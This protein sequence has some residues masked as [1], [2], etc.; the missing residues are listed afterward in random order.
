MTDSEKTAFQLFMTEALEKRASLI[1]EQ[2]RMEKTAAML[3]TATKIAGS[4]SPNERKV[5][6]LCALIDSALHALFERDE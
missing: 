3:R 5:D 6:D 2:R 1:Q 4:Q